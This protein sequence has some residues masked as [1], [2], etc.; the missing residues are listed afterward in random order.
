MVDL[1]IASDLHIEYK[2]DDIP[3]PLDYITPS[4]DIL[5]L[6]GDIGSLYKIEQLEGFLVKLCVHFKYVIYVPGNQEY[7]TFNEYVPIN[8]NLLLNR[9]YKIEQ[10]IKNLYVLNKSSIM[11]ENICITGCTLWSDL[12]ITIPKFIVRIHGINNEIY[13]NKFNSDLKYIKKMIDYCDN[14]NFKLCFDSMK[15]KLN[16]EFDEFLFR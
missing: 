2:N 5:I 12:K 15:I 3:D 9:L 13:T 10:N 4:A 6:A 1:Q 7:Y 14:N 11:I 16:K 8:M